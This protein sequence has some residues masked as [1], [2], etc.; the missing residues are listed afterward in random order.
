MNSLTY[1]IHPSQGTFGMPVLSSYEEIG[2]IYEDELGILS[3]LIPQIPVA[4][5]L[6]DNENYTANNLLFLPN[7]HKYIK[8]NKGGTFHHP[9]Q[10][11]GA[12]KV[13]TST[14]WKKHDTE[15]ATF[16]TTWGLPE[17]HITFLSLLNIPLQHAAIGMLGH[18]DH[19][20]LHNFDLFSGCMRESN[21]KLFRSDPII[22]TLNGIYPLCSEL[23]AGNLFYLMRQIQLRR[24]PGLIDEKQDELRDVVAEIV[25]C[26]PDYSAL[27]IN[28]ILNKYEK[29][30][31]VQDPLAK[32]IRKSQKLPDDYYN[33][34]VTQADPLVR[35]C[36]QVQGYTVEELRKVLD[37][38]DKSSHAQS[39]SFYRDIPT[40][41]VSSLDYYNFVCD[42]IIETYK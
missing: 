23:F 26:D 41:S 8:E 1:Y 2:R 35:N 36:Y 18:G 4:L 30:M 12:H 19:G 42:K 29:V 27:L 33:T 6:M 5:A 20:L 21:I 39:Q 37:Y 14:S 11:L 22:I 17:Q 34:V 32:E 38:L 9:T 40:R 7:T 16:V 15:K 31:G 25:K 13:Y 24:S 28:T 3:E 10:I